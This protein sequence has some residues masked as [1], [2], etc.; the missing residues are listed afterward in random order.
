[1][2]ASTTPP[3]Q[4]PPVSASSPA[5]TLWG[6]PIVSV[7][8]YATFLA[9]I[10]V[11]VIV[12]NDALLIT[13]CGMAGANATTAVQWWLGSSKGSADKSAT[14]ERQG[15]QMATMGPDAPAPVVKPQP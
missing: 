5:V 8:A 14:I 2:S 9:A 13:L 1:V 15:A 12:K 10:I 11:A 6:A 7:L 3:V 4:A